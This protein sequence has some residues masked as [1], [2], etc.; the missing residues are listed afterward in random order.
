MTRRM[1]FP[2]LL[3]SVCCYMAFAC[4][5][6]IQMSFMP[7]SELFIRL[8]YIKI[9]YTFFI[10]HFQTDNLKLLINILHSYFERADNIEMKRVSL[11]QFMPK[12]R[13][14]TL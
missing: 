8:S 12:N 11:H 4:H 9:M 10:S 3:L 6:N 7:C 14:F 2:S 1:N 13:H 5:G